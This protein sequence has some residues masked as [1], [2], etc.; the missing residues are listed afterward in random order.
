MRRNHF[1]NS[2]DA[3]LLNGQAWSHC[4]GLIQAFEEAWGGASTLRSWT[5]S[6]RRAERQM[7]LGRAAARR[8]GVPP[9]NGEPGCIEEYLDDYPS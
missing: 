7:L 4:E 2:A 8:S 1:D 3:H 9:Q 6:A 5:I